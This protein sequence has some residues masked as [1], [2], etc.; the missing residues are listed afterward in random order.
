M[1]SKGWLVCVM[2]YLAVPLAGDARIAVIGAL[3]HERSVEPGQTYRGTVVVQNL[4]DE[5]EE[6]RTYQT[7]FLFYSDGRSVYGEPGKEE[8]SNAPWITVSPRETT[9]PAG[10]TLELFYTIKVPDDRTLIGTYWSMLMIQEANKPDEKNSDLDQKQISFG[11]RQVFRYGVQF[12]THFGESG[13]RDVKFLETTK[14]LYEAQTGTEGEPE[15]TEINRFLQVDIENTGE[16][17]VRPHVWAEIYNLDSV[18]IGKFQS[19]VLRIYPGTSVRHKINLSEVPKGIYR[20]LVIADC[21]GD[22]VFG[23]NYTLKLK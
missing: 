22:Y 11:V 2:L 12:I 6:L 15:K 16:R 7:D 17:L 10:G 3:T 1:R 20:A 19:G 13:K 14:L 4:A 18:Y 8:R 21:G 5:P 9:I 23:T